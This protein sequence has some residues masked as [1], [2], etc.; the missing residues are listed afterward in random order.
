MYRH[1]GIFPP[2]EGMAQGCAVCQPDFCFQIRPAGVQRYAYH[3]F[4][5]VI[6]LI[7]RHP[8]SSAAVR[9]PFDGPVGCHQGGGTMVEGPVEFHAAGNPG[10][11][12][13]DHGRLDYVLAV[14]KV[15]SCG[16][17]LCCE[18]LSAK[19]RQQNHL[20]IFIFQPDSGVFPVDL[21]ILTGFDHNGIGI[22][23]A[24]CALMVPV[25]RKHGQLFIMR[26]RIGG[27]RHGEGDGFHIIFQ[28]KLDLLSVAYRMQN[29]CILIDSI[30]T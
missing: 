2:Q 5:P 14:E 9:V 6:R 18:N 11:E 1:S 13:P 22:G 26:F 16:F 23:I 27:N 24:A 3:A 8:D 19:F 7:F 28:H 25:F 12:S 20:D 4:H 15:V 17:V 29:L 30:I 10:A 21:L